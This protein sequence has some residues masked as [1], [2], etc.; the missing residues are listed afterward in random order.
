MDHVVPRS[1]GGDS[2]WENAVSSC[3]RCNTTKRLPYSQRGRDAAARK[4][5][6]ATLRSSDGH[7]AEQ[8]AV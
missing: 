2:T 5:K 3:V 6:T 7:Q 4:S 8:S 1:Q